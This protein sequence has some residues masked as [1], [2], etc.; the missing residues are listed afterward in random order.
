MK[1]D[2][3]KATGAHYTPPE[4]AS[5]LAEVTANSLPPGKGPIEA[6]DPACGDGALLLAL[7][8]A[9]P[10]HARRRLILV[11][12]ETDREALEQARHLLA[13][14][15]VKKVVLEQQ[16][17][18]AL[19]GIDSSCHE[20]QLSLLDKEDPP[21]FKQYDAIIANPPYVR[22][23]VLGASRAQQLARR[24]ALLGR[25]D[26]YYAFAKAM[27]GALKA[28][29]VLGL[30]TSNRFLTIKS[31][32]SLRGLLR[33][34]FDLQAIYDLGDTKLFSAAV[35]PV[36]VTARKQKPTPLTSC[37]FSRVYEYRHSSRDAVK[38][39]KYAT[40]F[41]ALRDDRSDGAVRTGTTTYFVERG[42]LAPTSSG[43][44]WSLRTPQY[45]KWLRCV[46]AKR[47]CSFGDVGHVRVGIK[48][49]A[50]E[51][52]IRDEWESLPP[53]LRP[54]D[55]LL[56]PLITHDD[57][58][59]WVPSRPIG[60]TRVLYPHVGEDGRRL[61]VDLHKYPRAHA[62]L[63]SHRER[64]TRR[65]YLIDAGRLWY[66]IWV[67]QNPTDWKLPK[68]VF[69]DISQYP[70][71]FLDTTGAVVNGDCYWIV[72]REGKEA[73]WLRLMLA[74]ANSSFITRFYDIM[75][76]N[77][78]YSGRRRFMTQYV[79]RFPLPDLQAPRAREV[80]ELV[81][82]LLRNKQVN[83][84]LEGK[85]DALVWEC[86]GLSEESVR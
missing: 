34:E 80:V 41:D 86:F 62:Y 12:Y 49:T 35:L 61:P 71:F 24:F 82:V 72:L 1:P 83:E 17:F 27:A 60:R 39:H 9:I 36:I 32:A 81:S 58:G 67:P 79:N 29:G 19:Q 46:E 28:G 69:P 51:V 70:R 22:T 76:H 11:G 6:L 37:S 13:D 43:E 55:E 30:L 47:L 59:R 5:F 64:L 42:V 26:L 52:F 57:T 25:V 65:K 4:L 16:D 23:Q 78:L 77:K 85:I 44:L 50:D 14:V 21:P 15:G 66:E 18:L 53:R 40:I 73:A 3:I 2:R 75:F 68:M 56:R 8:N 20:P 63:V 38:S 31:G 7:A 74:V 10:S 84:D 54:E 48:T 33:T 45:Q